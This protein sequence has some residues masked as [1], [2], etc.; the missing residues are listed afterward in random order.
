M[1]FFS[2]NKKRY[3]ILDIGYIKL[4][5]LSFGMILYYLSNIYS[6]YSSYVEC[7]I[8]LFLKHTG[9]STFLIIFY[10]MT[11]LNIELGFKKNFYDSGVEASSSSY[12]SVNEGLISETTIGR[13]K[14]S[15][16][17]QM[18]IILP[19]IKIKSYYIHILKS[20]KNNTFKCS[21]NE[22]NE[23]ILKKINKVKSLYVESAFLY[24]SNILLLILMIYGTY[25]I[26]DD[27]NNFFPSKSG[28]WVYK[29]K[30]ETYDLILSIIE[31]LILVI[32]AIKGNQL[33]HYDNVFKYTNYITYSS[34]IGIFIGPLLNVKKKK[35]KKKKLNIY[36]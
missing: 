5:A 3:I 10:F 27:K 8:Y 17:K 13:Q 32:F 31:F 21:Y 12:N 19:P 29:C 1:I 14:S 33:F 34:I 7:S 35:K 16:K 18:I 20:K 22:V 23:K 6:T 15:I 28:E 30:L 4:M 26:N 36:I 9:I 2:I 25:Q 11:E 24:S